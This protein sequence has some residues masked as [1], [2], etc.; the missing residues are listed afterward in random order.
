MPLPSVVETLE[1]IPEKAREFYRQDAD[2]KRFILDAE[3][4]ASGAE[5]VGALKRAL[6]REKAERR[7]Y[8]KLAEDRAAVDPEEFRRLKAAE[9][10]RQRKED[11][12]KGRFE[13][14]LAEKDSLYGEKVKKL[15]AERDAAAAAMRQYL[16]KTEASAACAAAG[17]KSLKVALPLI[18]PLLGADVDENGN[19]RVWVKDGEGPRTSAKTNGPMTVAELL[20]ELKSDADY[21]S[22]FNSSGA[23]GGGASGVAA[24]GRGPDL[25]NLSPVERLTRIRESRAH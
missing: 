18:L 9:E 11:I 7:K 12:E 15:E 23:T 2:G 3:D 21:G 24:S 6:E 17:V 1:E 14:V 19:A 20:A 16:I 13:K 5:D 25:S 10:E 22:I 8:A 4:V